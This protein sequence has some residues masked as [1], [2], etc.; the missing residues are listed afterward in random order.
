[1]SKFVFIGSHCIV[2]KRV[3]SSNLLLIITGS[4]YQQIVLLLVGYA[5]DTFLPLFSLLHK[6]MKLRTN[7]LS[8][9]ITQ[10]HFFQLKAI[11]IR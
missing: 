7:S 3:Q 2:K 1:M 11:N 6:S 5:A 10:Q 4:N 8:V 9:L